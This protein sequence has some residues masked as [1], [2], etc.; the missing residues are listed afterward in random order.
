MKQIISILALTL[1]ACGATPPPMEATHS[2]PSAIVRT[3]LAPIGDCSNPAAGG[4]WENATP[5][6][7]WA[8][9]P[10][11]GCGYG[12]RSFA[13]DPNATGTRMLGTCAMGVYKTTDC[14]ATWA[15]INTGRNAALLDGSRQWAMLVDPTSGATDDAGVTSSQV[16]YTSA[17]YGSPTSPMLKTSNGGVDWDVSWPPAGGSWAGIVT[18]N[19]A[20][21]PVIDPSNAQHLLLTFHA[22]CLSPHANACFGE[23]TDGGSTWSVVE[24]DAR[25]TGSLGG[26]Y[27]WCVG[28]NAAPLADCTHLLYA[29]QGT[30]A[31]TTGNYW[32]SST[33]LA[34]PWTEVVGLEKQE[35]HEGGQLTFAGGYFYMAVDKG[36]ARS[37]SGDTSWSLV[38]GSGSVG[39][40]IATD[41]VSLFWTKGYSGPP[42]TL[43]YLMKT[44]AVDAGTA[45]STDTSLQTVNGGWLNF[46][47]ALQEEEG[48]MRQ[49]GFW[50]RR[51]H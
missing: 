19:F 39:S 29:N 11:G 5:P 16:W 43:G 51:L 2:A 48:S 26:Q 47:P 42:Y 23:S 31:G 13:V 17:G 1:F 9:L 3:P 6:A 25:W 35:G 18:N 49:G 46:D 14:G 21:S 10:S 32:Y 12:V 50:R 36:V 45:W 34:G 4:A 33:G 15:H 24:G 7:V 44:A 37:V 20:G 22:S 30:Y 8:Q 40:G 27:L 28:T 38:S 41:G